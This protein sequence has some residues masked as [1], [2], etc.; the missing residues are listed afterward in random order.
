[1]IK[2]NWNSKRKSLFKKI[3]FIPVGL[4]L[5]LCFIA[6]LPDANDGDPL[7]L[8]ELIF[9]NIFI[10]PFWFAISFIIT[11]VVSWIINKS[12]ENV[13][14]KNMSVSKNTNINANDYK[15]IVSNIEN[16][17][18]KEEKNVISNK[19]ETKKED[20]RKSND[21]CFYTCESIIDAYEFKKMAKYF[22]KRMYW[23]FVI[24][25]TYLN[26]LLSAIFA[27]VFRNFIGTL[28]FFIL[29]ELYAMLIYKLELEKMAEKTFNSYLKKGLSDTDIETE[30]YED[31]FIRKGKTLSLTIKYTDISRRV[32]NDTNFYLEYPIRNTVVIIQ[33]NKCDL[34]LINFIREKFNNL[35]SHSKD[36]SKVK[37]TEKYHNLKFIKNMMTVLFILSIIS[38]WASMITWMMVNEINNIPNI[39]F[40]KTAWVTWFWLPIPILSTILGFKYKNMGFMCTKN[41]V[42]G[43]IVSFLLLMLGSFCFFPTF[44]ED[45]DKIYAYQDIIGLELPSNGLLEIRNWGTYFD[46][47]K[48]EYSVIKV[49]Y[50]KEDVSILEKEIEGGSN[51]GLS[52]KIKSNLK[53]FIPPTFISDADVYY[54]IYNKTL[55]EY[56]EIP[57]E[58]GFY[59]IY[60]MKYDKSTKILEIHKFNYSYK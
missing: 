9:T 58:E 15:L 22:P 4:W 32:E 3:F 37:N 16:N 40:N 35:E 55:D 8:G 28:I 54:S 23:V 33:K 56:N 45:Y 50:N 6:M 43:L 18:L 21:K 42:A 27:I 59:E 34:E 48:T 26:I 39:I 11:S 49:Y 14:E 52:T 38:V 29:F 13:E 30:F 12:G 60:T 25:G 5:V 1:M 2:N 51:W 47:D 46:V 31:Y 7:T 57:N 20:K 41:I 10:I 53:I 36:S 17:S 19:L 24:R 44:E